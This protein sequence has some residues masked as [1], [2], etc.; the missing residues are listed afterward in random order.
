MAALGNISL[1]DAQATPVAHV[2]SPLDH[3]NGRY[4]WRE[5][6]AASTLA[7]VVLELSRLPVKN[8]SG[9]EKVRVRIVLPAL[10]TI[11]GQNSSGYTAAPRLAYSLQVT[12]DY[13]M[14][15]RATLQQRTDLMKYNRQL[16]TETGYT[17]ISDAVTLGVWP[18]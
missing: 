13:I 18:F 5:N 17:Q 1:Y 8:G 12:T 15:N 3:N 16:N 4:Q 6:G 9:L 14:S 7:A 11:T 2:F 10:E